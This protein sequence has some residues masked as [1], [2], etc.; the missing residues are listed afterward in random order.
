MVFE[1]DTVYRIDYKYVSKDSIEVDTGDNMITVFKPLDLS[2]KL[3]LT[4]N[5]I[6][7]FLIKKKFEPIGG[8][9][10]VEFSKKL[11]WIDVRNE[12][13]INKRNTLINKSSGK[14]GYW[15]IKEIHS[16][17]FLVLTFDGVFDMHVFQI[18]SLENCIMQVS[19]IQMPQTFLVLKEEVTELKTCL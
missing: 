10:D 9:I 2:H 8:E 16:N 12:D 3:N 11:F 14:E 5:Q 4:K 13:K 18:L 19:Q 1:T 15:Y 7:D 6:S 17:F